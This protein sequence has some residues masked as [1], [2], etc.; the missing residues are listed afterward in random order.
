MKSARKD[1]YAQRRSARLA[2]VNDLQSTTKFREY[3]AQVER[4]RTIQAEFAE[5]TLPRW[6]VDMLTREL[7]RLREGRSRGG[8]RPRARTLNVLAE[9]QKLCAAGHRDYGLRNK[10]DQNLQLPPGTARKIL[11]KKKQATS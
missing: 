3:A 11:A 4:D 9:A 8:R 6:L 5:V 10:I 7:S 1:A 2:A